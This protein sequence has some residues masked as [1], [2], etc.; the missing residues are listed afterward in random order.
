MLFKYVGNNEKGLNNQGESTTASPEKTRGTHSGWTGR[1][2]VGVHW[3]PGYRTSH[4]LQEPGRP[5]GPPACSPRVTQAEELS[6]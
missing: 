6:I 4:P 1:K 5:S 2:Q 3:G